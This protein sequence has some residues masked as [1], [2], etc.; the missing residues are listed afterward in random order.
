MLGIGGV[1]VLGA[2]AFVLWQL[3]SGLPGQIAY[4]N[5]SGIIIVNPDGSG[6]RHLDGSGSGDSDPTWSIDNSLIA[7]D[8]ADGIVIV[9]ADSGVTRGDGDDPTAVNPA[10]SNTNEIA[11]ATGPAGQ[12]QVQIWVPPDFGVE[13]IRPEPVPAEEHDPAWS[14]DRE[15]LAFASTIDG[16]NEII[17]WDRDAQRFTQIT[18]NAADD[19]DPDWSRDGQTIVFASDQDGSFDIWAMSP[20]GADQESLTFGPASDHDPTWSPDGRAIA[21]S[22]SEAPGSAQIVVR[23]METGV[24]QVITS[25]EGVSGHPSWSR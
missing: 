14:P 17:I 9:D 8:G 25:G 2:I 1:A 7:Y 16:D 18:D 23:D 10:W 15:R 20:T 21:F 5:G 13:P 24:E 19:R 3:V 6:A 12:R 11:I 4:E 22:R